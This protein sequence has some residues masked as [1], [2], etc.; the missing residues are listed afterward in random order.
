MDACAEQAAKQSTVQHRAKVLKRLVL[1][2]GV[3]S[4]HCFASW[5]F[6]S[7]R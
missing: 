5:L 2:V 7:L 6:F 3:I 4:S 1:V